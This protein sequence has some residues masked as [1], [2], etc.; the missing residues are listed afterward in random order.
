MS[1]KPYRSVRQPLKTEIFMLVWMSTESIHKDR[2]SS[3]GSSALG[4]EPF[5]ILLWRK[6]SKGVCGTL[7]VEESNIFGNL[8]RDIV[9]RCDVQICKQLGLYPSVDG[10]HGGIVRCRASSGHGASDV[11]HG[12]ETAAW[13]A[14]LF[15][16]QLDGEIPRKLLDYLVLFLPIGMNFFSTPTPSVR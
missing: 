4:R 15:A 9:C 5:L 8:P 6:V 13:N 16:E 3:V 14:H 10:F 12:Q 2:L 7:F 11:I 1:D